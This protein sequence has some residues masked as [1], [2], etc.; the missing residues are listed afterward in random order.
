MYNRRWLLPAGVLLLLG[1]AR[2]CCL[3]GLVLP[4][5]ISSGSMYSALVGPHYS[6]SCADCGFSI[7][8]DATQ[9]SQS[10][11]VVCPNCGFAKN[12]LDL[13]DL[14]PGQRVLIDRAAFALRS[15]NR[16]ELVALKNPSN[17]QRLEVK[18]VVGLPQEQIEI[19]DGEVYRDGQILRKS[20]D[21]LRS[22]AVC[23]HDHSHQPA[24]DR[25]PRW[26][27]ENPGTSG[28][29]AS[30]GGF[31]QAGRAQHA[32]RFDWITYRHQACFSGP[33]AHDER[34]VLDN[35]GYN[36]GVS[37][38]LNGVSDLLLQCRLEELQGAGRMAFMVHDGRQAWR[39]VW[40]PAAG[41]VALE[42]SE[43]TIV[44]AETP[45]VQDGGIRV[46]YSICDD[47]VVF[48]LDG[49]TILTHPY[50]PQDSPFQPTSR[51]LA[52]GTSGV[53]ARV[54]DLRVF[55]DIYYLDPSFGNNWT[56]HS[57]L[58]L[59]EYLVLGDNAPISL[60]SRFWRPPGIK[61][62]SLVGK[63]LTAF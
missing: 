41:K 37:R 13:Q 57:P 7:V 43:R 50:R 39:V 59:D 20:I 23:V 14:R 35:Y 56:G 22:V 30:A 58:A 21:Q 25:Q 16:W 17:Q 19:R 55:R 28:W 38:S 46:E 40:T 51:P 24:S 54:T 36:Q 52:I 11:F 4:V 32:R 61:R 42:S 60:D 48:A 9:S 2:L 5:R 1:V 27:A 63:V 8:C 34:P 44:K 29:S 6:K 10:G 47:Q 3:Q 12:E 62:K 18:R 49:T 26:A 31:H 53:S 15:P 33:A 45:R